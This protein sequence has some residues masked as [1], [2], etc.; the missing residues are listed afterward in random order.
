MNK[1]LYVIIVAATIFIIDQLSKSYAVSSLQLY[2]SV[3]IVPGFFNITLMHNRGI[4]FGLLSN[5]SENLRLALLVFVTFIVLIVVVYKLWDEY[6]DSLIAVSALGLIVG[7]ALGNLYDRA[8]VGYVVD[9]IDI[10]VK[11]SHWPAFNI[12][13]SAICVGVF[14][15]VLNDFFFKKALVVS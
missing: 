3:N 12:A 15:L 5:L 10:Y 7:G 13:D 2:E 14:L 11:Q 4:A 8:F 1:K 6:K 9:F